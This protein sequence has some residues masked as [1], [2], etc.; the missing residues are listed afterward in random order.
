MLI[1][2][3]SITKDHAEALVVGLMSAFSETTIAKC[4]AL[5]DQATQIQK[6]RR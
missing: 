1:I 4:Q 6:V 3:F 2:I 5:Q